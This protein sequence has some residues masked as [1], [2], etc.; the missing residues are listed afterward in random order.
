MRKYLLV[1]ATVLAIAI[2]GSAFAQQPNIQVYFGDM[3]TGSADCPPIGTPAGT[4]L[5]ELWVVA[6]NFNTWLSA[7]EFMIVYPPQL[8]FVGDVNN[9]PTVIGT[10]ATGISLAWTMPLNAF[11]PVT[12]MK[13]NTLWMCA[14]CLDNENAPID[15]VANPN[16]GLLRGVRWPDN[17]PFDITGMRSLICATVPVEDTTWGQI[18]SLYN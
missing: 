13:V 6:N 10:S 17:E 4:E 1:F 14:G 18:K 11:V 2:A 12:L 16:Q 8:M 9:T 3:S 15:V 7:V 5:A